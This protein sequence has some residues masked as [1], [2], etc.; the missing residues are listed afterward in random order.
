VALVESWE[1]VASRTIQGQ[2]KQLVMHLRDHNI[3]IPN[4]SGFSNLPMIWNHL[5]SAEEQREIGLH[6]VSKLEFC[7]LPGMV[8]LFQGPFLNY[9]MNRLDHESCEDLWKDLIC[10]CVGSEGRET[11]I[12]LVL[13]KNC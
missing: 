3:V 6:F 5:V 8:S 13:R 9:V 11:P 10:P 7:D 2:G 12:F 4:D 1:G